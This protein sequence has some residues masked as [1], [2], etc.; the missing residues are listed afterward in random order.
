MNIP[1]LI[2]LFQVKQFIQDQ[3]ST[4]PASGSVELE[5]PQVEMD[6]FS[7]KDDETT[8]EEEENFLS[9]EEWS[10]NLSGAERK[11]R[12]T[13]RRKRKLRRKKLPSSVTLPVE[14][15]ENEKLKKYWYQRYRLFSKFDKGIRLDEGAITENTQSVV[16]T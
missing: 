3:S 13:K 16:K 15:Q 6:D 11:E 2:L 9:A 14:I 12:P 1:N 7:E 5:N 8:E 4:Q 10:A